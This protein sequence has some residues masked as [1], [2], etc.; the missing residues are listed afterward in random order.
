MYIIKCNLSITLILRFSTYTIKYYLKMGNFVF[1]SMIVD[2]FL[3][4]R[5][6]PKMGVQ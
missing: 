6:V 4:I 5:E 3:K 2:Y 1:L